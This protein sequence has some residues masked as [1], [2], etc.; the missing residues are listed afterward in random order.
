M[1]IHKEVKV[2]IFVIIAGTM[3]YTG[4]NFL[5]GI[6][7]FS[8]T[9]RYYAVYPNVSGLTVSNPVMMNGLAVGRVGEI[10]I[11][12][13]SAQTLQVALD[14]KK[15]VII[16]DSSKSIISNLGLLGGK[17]IVIKL[18][19][20]KK[21]I[22]EKG[23]LMSEIEKELTD[24]VGESL[25]PIVSNLDL[26]I[27][28]VNGI[29]SEKNV[30]NIT[31]M[32]SN[33][34]QTTILLNKMLDANGKT[35]YA[36]TSNLQKLTGSLVETEKQLKPLLEKANTLADSLN[37]MKLVSTIDNANKAI[38]ELNNMLGS[39]NKGEGTA[40]K[41]L[42]NDSLYF[43][44]NNTAR[45]LDYLMVDLKANPKRYVH[46]SLFGAKKLK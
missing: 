14:I 24:Q 46:F 2:A 32:I 6:D 39:L 12:N 41:L 31:S 28:R 44:L 21:P 25:S 3:L 34:E 37:R 11:M 8:T 5:K 27:R 36:S 30:N 40:G 43:N 1:K 15:D 42:H 35:I 22:P 4:F 13:D 38:T 18:G 19:N 33:L 26:T 20:Q 45:D 23:L 17:A 16:G 29:L 10:V 7:F 9:K